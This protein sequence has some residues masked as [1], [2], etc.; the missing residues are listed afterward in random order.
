MGV[1]KKGGG[2]DNAARVV[3]MD[4]IS[5]WLFSSLKEVVAVYSNNET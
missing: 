4:G 1:R 5:K 2:D 3:W